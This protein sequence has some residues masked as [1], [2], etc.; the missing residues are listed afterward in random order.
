M[1]EWCFARSIAFG[2]SVFMAVGMSA[3]AYGQQSMAALPPSPGAVYA[4]LAEEPLVSSSLDLVDETQTGQSSSPAP[5]PAEENN[6]QTKR[7]LGLI[8]NFR[9]VNVTSKLPPQTVKE[10]FVDATEDSF[11][12]SSFILPGIIAIESQWTDA[13]P[14]FHQGMAGFGRY[15]WHALADQTDENYWVEFIIPTLTHEDTRFYT[16]G[17]GGFWKRTEY[18][19]TRV[20]V[21]RTDDDKRSFN[22][23]EIVGGGAAAGIANLYYPP[24]QRGLS[25]TVSRW[26]LNVG[27]DDA[28]YWFK[29]FWPDINRR[30]FHQSN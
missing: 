28:S 30:F 23:G 13:T 10:K 4:S 21:V 12:Y 9:A 29:E 22:F 24:S 5:A 20:L 17:K 11:D 26:V 19:L 8:P 14:E 3:A 7:I 6:G 27:I 15:Y 2:C 1:T 25:N 16:L 18:A